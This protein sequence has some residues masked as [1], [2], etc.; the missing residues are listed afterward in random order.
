MEDF[1]ATFQ[2]PLGSEIP[3]VIE[4]K[5]DPETITPLAIEYSNYGGGENERVS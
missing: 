3:F 4:L 2:R 1:A 5:V